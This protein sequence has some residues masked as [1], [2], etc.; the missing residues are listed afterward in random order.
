MNTSKEGMDLITAFE[1]FSAKP[2]LD[3]G[4]VPTIGYGSTYYIDGSKVAI[5]DTPISKE[6]AIKLMRGTL[7][8][9]EE[10]VSRA[11]RKPI[12]QNQFDACVSL[13]YNIGAANFKKSTLVQMI[14][15]GKAPHDIA[16]QFLRWDHDNGKTVK[17]L[18][19]RRK[20]EMELFLKN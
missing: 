11:V 18:T 13:A 19:N 20:A 5:H 2:Y 16:A 9:Y 1:G 6:Q 10:A 14:N 15:D 4:G 7:R 8:Q 17:G 12:K 3:G